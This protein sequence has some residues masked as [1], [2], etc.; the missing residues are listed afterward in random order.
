[1]IVLSTTAQTQVS[2]AEGA[3]S[4]PQDG[5]FKVAHT[6]WPGATEH[7]RV[8][9]HAHEP[10]GDGLTGHDN[11]VN[12]CGCSG[13]SGSSGLCCSA[14]RTEDQRTEGLAHHHDTNDGN[15]DG[16]VALWPISE[17]SSGVH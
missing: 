5:V 6:G 17:R 1:V 9:G 14:Q 11:N 2:R 7:T 13:S 8:N 15:H 4:L 12:H 16:E 3:C 10:V